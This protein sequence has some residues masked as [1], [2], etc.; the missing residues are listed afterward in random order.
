MQQEEFYYWNLIRRYMLIL[1]FYVKFILRDLC[2]NILI[3]KGE[4]NYGFKRNK[5]KN[6]WSKALLL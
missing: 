6:V 2:K 5:G 1:Y 4:E 3:G